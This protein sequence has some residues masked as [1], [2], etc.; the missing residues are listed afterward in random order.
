MFYCITKY[1][2]CQLVNDLG[3]N[4]GFC[5]ANLRLDWWGDLLFVGRTRK[6]TQYAAVFGR[7]T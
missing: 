5:R 7:R 6:I 1:S 2:I 4:I 3:M